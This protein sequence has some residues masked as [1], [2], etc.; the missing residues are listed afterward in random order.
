M[1]DKA[2]E[3]MAKC[4]ADIERFKRELAADQLAAKLTDDDVSQFLKEVQAWARSL[5]KPQQPTGS[6]KYKTVGTN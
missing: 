6:R 5:R 2:P 1:S 3:M 4:R